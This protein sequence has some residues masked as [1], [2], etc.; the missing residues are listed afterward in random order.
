M[1][2]LAGVGAS[3][4]PVPSEP[5]QAVNAQ[6]E[7]PRKQA[8]RRMKHL[9]WRR[10]LHA[11]RGAAKDVTLADHLAEDGAKA[12]VLSEWIQL[13]IDVNERDRMGAFFHGPLQQVERAFLLAGREIDLG[14]FV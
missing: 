2:T 12:R 7:R 14:Q 1:A 6:I 5:E 9:R 10:S 11:C 13:R 3:G 4:G 8:R